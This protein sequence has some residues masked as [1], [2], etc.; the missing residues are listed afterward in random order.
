MDYL[1]AIRVLGNKLDTIQRKYLINSH[2]FSMPECQ[3]E[4]GKNERGRG[5]ISNA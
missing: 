5:T 1:D 2:T 4:T 3:W